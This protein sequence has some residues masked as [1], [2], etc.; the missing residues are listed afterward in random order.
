MKNEQSILEKFR[1]REEEIKRD[2]AELDREMSKKRSDRERAQRAALDKLEAQR[3]ALSR[4]KADY[5]AIEAEIEKKAR[6]EIES[7]EVT[8]EKVKSGG[9]SIREFFNSGLNADAITA[10]AHKEAEAKLAEPMKLIRDKALEIFNLELEEAQARREIVFCATYPGQSQVARLKAEIQ[11]L[12]KGIASVL[13]DYSQAAA[14][15]DRAKRDVLLCSNGSPSG[16][17]FDSLTFEELKDLRFD[18]RFTERFRDQLENCISSASADHRYMLILSPSNLG[19][20]EAG[21]IFRALDDD[22]PRQRVKR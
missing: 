21:L 2:A 6:V 14:D 1:E 17:S 12:E 8:G 19:G 16:V 15:V 18:P 9:A 4:M 10:R 20:R 11:M 22:G 7:S 3:A 5:K 13:G